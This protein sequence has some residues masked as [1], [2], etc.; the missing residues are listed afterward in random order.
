M[1]NRRLRPSGRQVVR[2]M[3]ER[4]E[5]PSE[6]ETEAGTILDEEVRRALRRHLRVLAEDAAKHVVDQHL[7]DPLPLGT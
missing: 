7:P 6:Y 2:D 5:I 1:W 4:G 3:I